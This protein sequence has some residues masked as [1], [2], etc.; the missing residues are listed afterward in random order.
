MFKPENKVLGTVSIRGEAFDILEI[1]G[2]GL[3][4]ISKNQNEPANGNAA[5]VAVSLGKN[6][7]PVY[8]TVDA[9]VLDQIKNL[10]A[11][12]IN[13]IAKTALELNGIGS[14]VQDSSVQED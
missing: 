1:N 2:H 11:R 14:S 3:L 4:A 7:M 5:I 10:P 9:K 6:G 13:F 8:P 12:D